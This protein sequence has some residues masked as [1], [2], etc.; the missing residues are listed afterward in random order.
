MATGTL[1]G[2]SCSAYGAPATMR[3][4]RADRR[5]RPLLP[6]HLDGYRQRRQP[7]PRSTRR[8]GRQ[9]SRPRRPSRSRTSAAAPTTRA[10]ARPSGSGPPPLPA[11]ST[12]PPAPPTPT[13][14]SPRYTFPTAGAMGRNWVVSGGG[15]TRTYTYRTGAANSG[16][17]DRHRHQPRRA[18]GDGHWTTPPTRPHPR[19]RPHRQRHC[20]HRRRQLSYSTSG[21]VDDQ[22]PHRLH[23]RRLRLRQLHPHRR[24]RH[25]HRQHL[26]G[27][28]AP[29]S[30]VGTTRQT[31]ASGLLP[32]ARSPDRPRRQHRHDHHHRHGRHHRAVR[33]DR[34]RSSRPDPQL[35]PRRRHRSSTSKAGPA[36]ASPPPPAAATDADSGVASYNYGNIAGAGWVE[37][38]RR[39][40]HLHRHLPHRHRLGDRHEQ[41]RPHRRERQLHRPVRRQRADRRR[42]L[43][44][45]HRRVRRRQLELPQQR[46]D[47]DDHE[48][49]RLQRTQSATE[50]GLASSTLTMPTGTLSGNRCS[51]YGAPAT[52]VGTTAQT[53]AT[54][55]VIC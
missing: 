40:V 41:R 20:S 54:G 45:R 2:N 23:R 7:S 24:H 47:V 6:A 51:A 10:P 11:P 52:I 5:Q 42:L 12:S 33:A 36:V 13:P 44:Q 31:H 14:A 32:A 35:L 55:T 27:Y 8:S 28:G 37:R 26:R 34:S 25:P 22:Q 30:I 49:H 15:A 1:S 4:H 38:R 17:A 43:R 29:S 48:P 19:R 39:G 16:S 53:V 46:H 9:P 50:S 3:H 18:S 21:N